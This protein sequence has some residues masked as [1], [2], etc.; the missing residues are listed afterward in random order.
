MILGKLPAEVAALFA[1]RHPSASLGSRS[2]DGSRRIAG[3]PDLIAALAEAGG[4]LADLTTSLPAEECL[5]CQQARLGDRIKDRLIQETGD[6]KACADCQAEIDRLN[7]MTHGEVLAE[8][9]DLSQRMVDRARTQASKYVHRTA[10]R[11]APGLTA[12]IVQDWLRDAV[13]PDGGLL[14]DVM[15]HLDHPAQPLE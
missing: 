14:K 11:I 15:E 9:P 6:Q 1:S 3:P 12:L 10:A 5:P 2:K 8:I 13:S 7:N 4:L